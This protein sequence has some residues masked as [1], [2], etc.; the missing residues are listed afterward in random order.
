[1]IRYFMLRFQQTMLTNRN[2][3]REQYPLQ[4]FDGSDT[5]QQANVG[6][7]AVHHFGLS[8]AKMEHCGLEKYQINYKVGC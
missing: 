7:A 5:Q 2:G 8:I 6:T 1:M 4:W 3:Y